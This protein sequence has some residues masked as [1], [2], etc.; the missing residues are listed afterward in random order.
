MKAR[1]I[2]RSR[3]ARVVRSGPTTVSA[4]RCAAALAGCMVFQLH[5]NPNGLSV[6][7]GSATATAS[8]SQLNV[9]ASSG[10]VLNWQS[11]NINSGETTIFQQPSATSVVF[12]NIY[13]QN[14]SQ[15][16]GNLQ[17][18]GIIILENQHGFFFGPNS[19]ISAPG[20]V[21]TT[22]AVTPRNFGSG[23]F[24]QFSGPPPQAHIVNYGQINAGP[25]SSIFLIADQ[26]ENH[27]SLSA[28]GGSIGLVSG[29]Q[30]LLSDR[31]DGRGLSAQV[32]LPSG[33]VDN[34]GRIVADA[35]TIELQAQVVN[36]NGIVQADSVREQNGVIELV[37]SQ[38]VT[39][40]PNSEISA[41]GGAGGASAGGSVQIEAGGSF[42]D[43]ASSTINVAG[44]SQGGNGG[45]VEISAPQISSIQS[46]INGAAAP[47]YTGGQLLIDPTEI[48]IGS[49]GSGT[50]PGSGTVNSGDAPGTL[51][52]NVNSSFTGFSQITLEACD[53]IT[54]ANNTSWNLSGS[55]GLGSGQL[56]LEAG[57]NIIFGN[58]SSV[59][60]PTIYDSGNW[61]VNLV[62]GMNFS[63]GTVQ[64]GVGSIFLNGGTGLNQNGAIRTAAG[65]ISL[66]A[67][68]DI[69][70]GSGYVNTTHGGISW[71]TPSPVT[72][73]PERCMAVIHSAQPDI[74]C[75]A[76]ARL[77]ASPPLPAAMSRSKQATASS[78]LPRSQPRQSTRHQAPPALMAASRETSPSSRATTL[79]GVSWCATALA[80]SNQASRSRTAR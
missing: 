30:V 47:G 17:A 72:S 56:L 53:D 74:Q 35:G 6:A 57:N 51:D 79:L 23:A 16:W 80:R 10:A 48:V 61:S 11:F 8:G 25:G 12:N 13:S 42:T 65:S 24:W 45:A 37:A 1:N 73:M 50:I 4:V 68:E 5:A 15:I 7:S 69:L 34:S 54:F 49:S 70:V 67:G 22:A 46:Q 29:Q 58:N 66:T 39:L 27:G 77:A 31:P 63:T 19:M 75:R 2:H 36:Q 20:F 3:R 44:G 43:N 64:P 55:T 71:P 78:A 52:L 9:T 59:T 32:T 14:P 28:P 76:A 33:S 62:A 18:N 21:A 40:G 60:T 26:V 41:R 38:D